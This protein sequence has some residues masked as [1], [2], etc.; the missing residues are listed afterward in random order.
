MCIISFAMSE[1]RPRA[2][3]HVMSWLYCWATCPDPVLIFVARSGQ[4]LSE[5][6]WGELHFKVIVCASRPAASKLGVQSS[7]SVRSQVSPQQMLE[8]PGDIQGWHCPPCPR[9][10][11][12]SD[13]T[14]HLVLGP[15]SEN[16]GGKHSF[17]PPYGK[18]FR[19][20][21]LP[22]SKFS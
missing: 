13:K 15:S 4:L 17:T 12:E 11:Q 10:S 2:L 20:I 22:C 6:L 16:Q 18:F 19:N 8:D 3:A 7:L 9:G 14:S 1:L 5:L 21:L